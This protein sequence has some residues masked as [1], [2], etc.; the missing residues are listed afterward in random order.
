MNLSLGI[1]D[2]PNAIS[3]IYES[4]SRYSLVTIPVIQFLVFSINS[5][6][7]SPSLLVGMLQWSS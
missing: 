2:T 4:F 6:L 7:E 1:L 5:I 3:S